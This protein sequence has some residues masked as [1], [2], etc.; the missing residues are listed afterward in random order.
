VS[1]DSPRRTATDPSDDPRPAN[2]GSDAGPGPAR[3]PVP[4]LVS[5]KSLAG[6]S[7]DLPVDGR[8]AATDPGRAGA[9]PSTGAPTRP[10]VRLRMP[11]NTARPPAEA[12]TGAA[13][14][15]ITPPPDPET[16]SASA[17]PEPPAP[18][19]KD[20]T[21]ASHLA[22]RAVPAVNPGPD[23]P[24]RDLQQPAAN[25]SGARRVVRLPDRLAVPPAPP[26]RA[27]NVEAT[28]AASTEQARPAAATTPDPG[29]V[30]PG[31]DPATS[32]DR[33]AARTAVVARRSP[34]VT[35]AAT[36]S[37]AAGSVR[38]PS[39]PVVPR[40]RPVAAIEPSPP[41]RTSPRRRWAL[42]SVAA[43][44]VLG[45]GV[46]VV[47][48][49]S[50]ADR[51]P[52]SGS[53]DGGGLAPTGATTTTAV[54][55]PSDEALR[56]GL[57]GS[58][59]VDVLPQQI[60]EGEGT[61]MGPDGEPQPDARQSSTQPEGEVDR[62]PSV[63]DA[64]RS[65]APPDP[66]SRTVRTPTLVTSPPSAGRASSPRPSRPDVPTVSGPG[67]SPPPSARPP[68]P[69]VEAPVGSTPVPVAPN[70]VNVVPPSASPPT[71]TPTSAGPVTENPAARDAVPPTPTAGPNPTTRPP[72]SAPTAPPTTRPAAS[73]AVAALPS[74]TTRV[75][76]PP[77]AS[78]PPPPTPSPPPPTPSPPPPPTAS[79]PPPPLPPPPTPPPTPTAVP[80]TSPAVPPVAP[81]LTLPNGRPF[82][83]RGNPPGLNR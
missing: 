21:A 62:S 20:Q 28:G 79:P 8:P 55:A 50:P 24:Q 60:G 13:A 27:T 15:S 38:G 74:P 4:K 54:R 18:S 77:T 16:S 32:P 2:A 46:A 7:T 73:P 78:P 70:P 68:N 25:P 10:T 53:D 17:E 48:V 57:G 80:T 19:A 45:A 72:S 40:A 66:P 35:V 6:S 61:S 37:V 67:T 34:A 36:R 51:P 41:R 14:P 23:R 44:I 42:S 75:V 47:G 43:M 65:T 11:T 56:P 83:G 1:N 30:P 3:R 63:P 52:V 9:D 81:P 12:T 69:S 29:T 58:A 31:P 76:P 39:R 82:P 49:P 5:P 59:P 26:Q 64:T 71:R 33:E 22:S